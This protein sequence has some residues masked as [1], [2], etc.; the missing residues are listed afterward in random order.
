MYPP[1][2]GSWLVFPRV[3]CLV[4]CSSILSKVSDAAKNLKKHYERASYWASGKEVVK[5]VKRFIFGDGKLEKDEIFSKGQRADNGYVADLVH[6]FPALVRDLGNV[7]LMSM[8]S[9]SNASDGE[10]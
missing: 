9:L 4:K 3:E 10:A 1:C 2:W 8:N 6:F 7:E 5:D